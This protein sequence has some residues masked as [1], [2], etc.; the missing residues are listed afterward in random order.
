MFFPRLLR[1]AWS[2]IAT[3]SACLATTSV[4]ATRSAPDALRDTP[5]AGKAEVE[6]RFREAIWCGGAQPNSDQMSAVAAY[7]LG[8]NHR[9]ATQRSK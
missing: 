7:I 5:G 6:K 9:A 2:V 4:A 1:I 8:L 3:I